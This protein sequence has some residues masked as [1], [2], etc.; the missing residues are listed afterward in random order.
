MTLLIHS[1]QQIDYRY[2]SSPVFPKRPPGLEAPAKRP[3]PPAAVFV[4]NPPKPVFAVLVPPNA[5]AGLAWF[6]N[7]PP[8]AVDAAPNPPKP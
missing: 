4:P 8:P 6:A 1:L 5:K 7:R 2:N 3:A